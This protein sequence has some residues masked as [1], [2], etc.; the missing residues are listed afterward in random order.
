MFLVAK[1]KSILHYENI[2]KR[3]LK[4]LFEISLKEVVI[5]S[6][7]P[8]NVIFNFS[9]YELSDVE[10]SVLCKGLTFSVKPKSIEYS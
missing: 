6:H 4:N 9:S 8:N 10:K 2:Q 5:D 7:D 3:K 1:D